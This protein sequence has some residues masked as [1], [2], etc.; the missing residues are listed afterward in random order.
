MVLNFFF[1]SRLTQDCLENLFSVVRLKQTVPNALQFKNNLKLIGISQ[2]MKVISNSNYDTDD[3]EF[4]DEFLDILS[5]N[6]KNE[7][8]HNIMSSQTE[9]IG[10][11]DTIHLNKTELN[12]LYLISGYI[13]KNIQRNYKTCS[14]CINATR[15]FQNLYCNSHTILLHIKEYKRKNMFFVNEQT[16]SFFLQMEK[17]FRI[18][19]D[20][21][22]SQKI[23]VKTFIMNKFFAIDFS[24]PGCHKL[25]D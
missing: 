20:Y 11:V 18:Y 1:P 23:N 2:Y 17:I 9:P 8:R 22:L 14:N 24:L 3:R 6:R 25:K 12:V 5:L 15:S 4:L 16:F 19:R 7:S 13:I 21:A 10:N